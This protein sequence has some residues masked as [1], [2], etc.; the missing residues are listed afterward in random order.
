MNECAFENNTDLILRLR[1]PSCFA[2]Q[3]ALSKS[4]V[5]CTDCKKTYIID[6]D[7][8]D[9]RV[10]P[11]YDT[12]L[13][14]DSYDEGHGI[15]VKSSKLIYKAY[16]KILDKYNANM[17]GELLEIASG[18]GH[19]TYGLSHFSS[20]SRINCSDI[21]P[22]FMRRLRKRVLDDGVCVNTL[23]YLFDANSFPFNEGVFDVVAGNSVLH[24]FANFENT[25]AD[26]FRV[27]KN[28]GVAIFGEPVFDT[29][30]FVSLASSLIRSVDERQET[31][32]FSD[33]EDRVLAAIEGRALLKKSNLQ[34]DRKNLAMEDKFQFPIAYMRELAAKLGYKQFDC[35][36]PQL[37]IDFGQMIKKLIINVFRQNKSDY[38]K[39]DEFE[40]IFDSL[41]TTYGE[42]MKEDIRSAFSI[43]VFV[44]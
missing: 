20:F 11:S 25:L 43:F 38:S 31:R 24:H 22:E 34:S 4:E 14:I 37:N 17:E 36:S 27:L 26:S 13:D 44:K 10:D 9:L 32:V 41:N 3:M 18:S 35:V 12:L 6:G 1:C 30:V 21:S 8:L 15:N 19:L 39:L 40:Y 29:H 42:P 5:L 23:S 28:N 2:G 16:E 7:V 33:K